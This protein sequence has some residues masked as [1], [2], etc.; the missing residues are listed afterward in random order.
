MSLFIYERDENGTPTHFYIGRLRFRIDQNLKPIP[1]L[2]LRQNQDD[3]GNSSSTS[4]RARSLS[5]DV[6]GHSYG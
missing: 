5:A 1:V 4:V 2:R 6:L 3:A